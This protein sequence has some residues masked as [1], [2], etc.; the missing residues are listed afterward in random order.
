MRFFSKPAKLRSFLFLGI[1][2]VLVVPPALAQR[3]VT[4][5]DMAEESSPAQAQAT[6]ASLFGRGATM[7]EPPGMNGSI[8]LPSF[9][10]SKLKIDGNVTGTKTED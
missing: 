7:P 5:E 10:N 6:L 4:E 2:T 8:A 1:L 3:G 9:D